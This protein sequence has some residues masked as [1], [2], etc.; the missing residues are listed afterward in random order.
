MTLMRKIYILLVLTFGSLVV[1]MAQPTIT[2][3]DG[4]ACS[5]ENFCVPF[6]IQDFT[7]INSLR[8]SV[9]YDP[10]VLTFTGAQNFNAS[11]QAPN[12]N[13]GPSLF[14][15]L[16]AGQISFDNWQTGDCNNS[17]NIGVTL[18]DE[19]TIFELC[20]TATGAYGDQTSIAIT[21][22]PT[23]IRCTRNA[24]LC[25]NIGLLRNDGQVTLCVREFNLT[26]TNVSGNAGDQVCVDM[27]VNGFDGLNSIQF[28]MQ[29]DPA[30]LQFENL[31]PN[32]EIPNNSLAAY[33]LPTQ[34]D[35]GPGNLT[36]GWSF[37]QQGNVT[38][39]SVADG[40]TFFT[41]C[42]T[43][44]GD[45]ETATP[46]TFSG[47]PTPIEV[48]NDD[49]NNPNQTNPLIPVSLNPGTV[50]VNDCNPTGIEITIDCG[51]PVEVND[52]VCVNFF[53][54]TNFQAV[55]RLEYLMTWNP[56]I[57][58]F[59]SV[60]DPGNN[61]SGLDPADFDTSN[62]GNGFLGLDW[63]F[64]AG[65]AQNMN[66]M[67][68]IYEVCFRVVGVGGDSPVQIITPGVGVSNGVDIGINPSNCVVEVIQPASVVVDFGDISA[69][70]NGTECVPVTVSNFNEVLS[71]DFS[72]AWDE[73]VWLYTG[74]QNINPLFTGATAANFTPVGLSST[75]FN[76]DTPTPLTLP[77]NTVIFE[78]CFTT[79]PTANPG[80]VDD[81]VTVGFPFPESAVT[82]TS[83]GENIGLIVN[84]A[85]MTVL[86]P[87]GFGLSAADISGGWL[88]TLCMNF[89]VA[90]FDNI[91]DATFSINWDPTVLSY[92]SSAPL[93]WTGVNLTP[94]P[95]GALNGTFTS[96][97]PVA[98]PDGSTAFQVCF[99]L[100]GDPN[101]CYPVTIQN[102]PA[103]T[104]QT[105]NGEGSIV[106]TNGEICV[107]E[108]IVIDEI[109][110]T[111][112]SCPGNCDGTVTITV[113]EWSGQGFIGTTWRTQPFEQFTSL[114]LDDICA[115]Q[116]IFTL[117][118]N[119]SGV[120]LTD[121][122]MIPEGGTIPTAMINGVSPREL[123]CTDGQ[124]L[125]SAAD[126]GPGFS[127]NWYNNAVDGSPDGELRQ[128]FATSPG[129]IIL[130]VT[131]QVGGCTSTDTITITAP[132]LPEAIAGP[133][134]SGV[135][136]AV[137]SATLNGNSS[138]GSNLTY[139]WSI[140]T[141]DPTRVDSLTI[142]TAN[143]VV[144]GP[145]RYRLTVT[146]SVTGCSNSIDDASDEVTVSDDRIFPSACIAV[147]EQEQNCDGLALSFDGSCSVNTGI[148]PTYEWFGV[149]ADGTLGANLGAGL[150]N[151]FADL[152]TYALLVTEPTTGCTDTAFAQIIPNS[153][154]PVVNIAEPAAFTCAID[155]IVLNASL[156]PNDP[157]F[158]FAWVLADGA[159]LRPG[160]E[161]SL[162]PTALTPGTYQVLVTNPANNCE[163]EA[164]V[165]LEDQTQLPLALIGND[166][167]MTAINCITPTVDLDGTPSEDNLVYQW[168]LGSLASPIM[169][170]TTEMFTATMDTTYILEVTN[171]A[172]AC[173]AT[174]S[175]VVAGNFDTPNITLNE[176]FGEINC[177]V[178]EVTVTATVAGNNAYSLSEWTATEGDPASIVLVSADTLTLTVNGAGV[179]NLMAT[180][181]LSGCTSEVDFSV[182]ENFALPNINVQS[183]LL[184]INCANGEVTLSG[185]GSST[186]QNVVYLWDNLDSTGGPDNPTA[187]Q[188]TTMTPGTYQFT[189]RDT[190]NGCQVDTLVTVVADT[191]APMASIAP[192]A[193][194][195]CADQSRQVTVDVTGVPN[196]IVLWSGAANP[197]PTN[198]PTTTINTPGLLQVLVTN[199]DNGCQTT[200][201]VTVAGDVTPPV[202][203]IAVPAEFDC[204][205]DMVTL[206]ASASGTT[207]DFSSLIWTNAAGTTLATDVLT[208]AVTELGTYQLEATSAANGCLGT[209][210]VTVVAAANLTLPV[211]AL[212]N[213]PLADF[214]CAGTPV[215]I[216]ASAT[217]TAADF[218][219]IVWTGGDFTDGASPFTI[220]AQDVG[221]YTLTVV[222]DGPVPGCEAS[223]TF[224]V[225]ADAN[226]P[227]ANAGADVVLECGQVRTLD[228]SAS[229]APS[230]TFV[231]TWQTVTGPDLTT[232][233]TG[234]MPTVAEP[235]S[236]Q[237]VVTNVDNDCIDTSAVVAVTLQLP[238]VTA[239]AGDNVAACDEVAD[240]NAA[241][242][243]GVQGVWTTAGGATIDMVSDPAT[244]VN[245]LTPGANVFTWTLSVDGC[246][247][248]S[249]DDVT[250]TRATAITANPD[251]LQ[252]ASGVGA[253]EV[254]LLAN[255]ALGGSSGFNISIIS[256]PG[257]GTYDTL[258]LAQG[259]LVMTFALTDFGT[260]ELTYEI[261][262]VDCPDICATATV[263][264]NVQKGD[265]IFVPNTITPNGDGANDELVFDILLFNPAEDFPD[266]EL[267]I[268]SRW[269]DIIYQAKPYANTWTGLNQDGEPVAEGTYYYVLRL[270]ISR[271]EIIR[272][273]ITVIR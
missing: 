89:T 58:A 166:P 182:A 74:V 269:G 50:Q 131:D 62:T 114:A 91:T 60:N 252:V 260:T 125:V 25:N 139:Q 118:D 92:A 195:T 108:Q 52:I 148:S 14:T 237:L 72:L 53:A 241:A 34:I 230:A 61:L 94:A 51:A 35:E 95:V 235:G 12:G 10:A 180:S 271:G 2:I 101:E 201:E 146:N 20:F 244:M 45:C 13:L 209:Q 71:M 265:E 179:Y 225:V 165:V 136:C 150:M 231:Y 138:V 56:N 189:V 147:P 171:S 141:G 205:D 224:T 120:T 158:T 184:T 80:D 41:V 21:N 216:D 121:T 48:S 115:G 86:F 228:A 113:R 29:Y 90:S 266:N 73:M 210:T 211:I 159:S 124:I 157:T 243:P 218:S 191:L 106:I 1:A 162:T 8:F 175:I 137:T 28:S 220:N 79:A 176:L 59:V 110:I 259:N 253:G 37:P 234:P 229:T 217:G 258:A 194:L 23:A 174:D 263:L 123:N 240:L 4:S 188:T 75:S 87:E 153:G 65:P 88:D 132:T 214:G 222:L 186:T 208:V 42:F 99:A 19:E 7:N 256:P 233:S 221:Q 168:Y 107:I 202:L 134:T 192:V 5:S 239:N 40:T 261:C 81:L 173:S 30:F 9:G 33:G 273:D 250:V 69:P 232:G 116:L 152:G 143:F 122:I 3:G 196:F 38:S 31:F 149:N 27:E 78:V 193:D 102:T 161:T 190:L 187:I 47:F 54:G 177:L 270:N 103:P 170:A 178:D 245:N 140:I 129:N 164:T 67:E 26:A 15:E 156:T 83:N 167:Q 18:P 169:G 185:A 39:A 133:V 24:T 248:F 68:F 163:A 46:I 144:N 255:D 127:Y 85:T 160:T 119:D 6:T 111:P 128:Y 254:N 100:V 264:I 199:T 64:T 96:P 215:V 262:S 155:S 105:T 206:D 66:N 223:E 238:A 49:P 257:F 272:G 212:S 204:G 43:I 55:R 246:P 181:N 142:N 93:A 247:D 97:T 236:Y 198:T 207:D 22:S 154:A 226:T 82:N 117:F 213:A 76:W 109:T 32:T 200:A 44:L 104:V 112:T 183:D 268:F 227:V 267:L 63:S 70:L 130:V 242:A 126:Q 77:D 203:S 98:I 197:T 219:S 251:V 84:P 16:T 57:L 249:S 145:G 17:S 36:V 172:T 11:M 151:S 135:T